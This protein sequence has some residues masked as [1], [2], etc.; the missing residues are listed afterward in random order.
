MATRRNHE[1]LAAERAIAEIVASRV[2]QRRG[3]LGMSIATLADAMGLSTQ[4]MQKI[5]TNKGRLNIAQAVRLAAVLDV[6]LSFLVDGCAG[7]GAALERPVGELELTRQ[8]AALIRLLRNASE[9]LTAAIIGLLKA[10]ASDGDPM[11]PPTNPSP[12]RSVARSKTRA[13]T[14]AGNSVWRPSDIQRAG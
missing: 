2:R 1:S 9:A 14:G 5:E 11:E 8:E 7:N 10:M 4:Q 12:Q 13:P 6:P 3:L